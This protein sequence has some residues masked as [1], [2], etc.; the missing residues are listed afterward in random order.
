M[1][2]DD[3]LVSRPVAPV[4]PNG[5]DKP[6]VTRV[7]TEGSSIYTKYLLKDIRV[8]GCSAQQ[9]TKS[10]RCVSYKRDIL[11]AVLEMWL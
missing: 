1:E 2:G 8:Q 5:D 10:L 4:T 11:Y 7:T 6:C 9:I 3:L